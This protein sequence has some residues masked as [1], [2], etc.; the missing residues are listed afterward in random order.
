LT[1][2][3]LVGRR[4]GKDVFKP[5]K[6]ALVGYCPRPQILDK[7]SPRNTSDQYFIHVP[8]ASVQICTHDG[9]PFLSLAHVYGGPVS[10][11]TIE[12]LAYYG[13]DTVLAYGL[14]GGLGTGDQKLGDLYIVERA[15]ALDG[16]TPHY[17]GDKLIPSDVGLNLKIKEMVELAGLPEMTGVQAM[18]TDAIYREYDQD[19]EYGRERGCDIVNCDSSHLFAASREVGIRSTECGVLSDVAKGSGEEWQS[20]LGL[21]LSSKGRGASDPIVSVGRIVEFYVETLMPGL[22]R[23]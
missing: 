10:S 14:A 19:L 22:L 9:V 16:T 8:P 23:G 12:E 2:A 4:F 7:Y 15:L 18:T 20:T 1:P 11:A 6:V 13:I 5:I 21:M 17:T 3:S